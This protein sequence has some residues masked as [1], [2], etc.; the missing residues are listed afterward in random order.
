MRI[1]NLILL[2]LVVFFVSITTL[3]IA[4]DRSSGKTFTTRSEVLARN[5][6]VATNHPL[7]TQ[8]GIEILK[9][10]GSAI[11]AAIAANAFLGFAD[12]GMNGIGGDLFA[13]VW[14][15]KT[16]KLYGLNASGRSPQSLTLA[17]LKEQEQ[18]K[19]FHY[20]GPLSVTTPGCIDGWFELN[21]RFGK[22]T[23][24]E[25]LQPV[26]RYAREGVPITQE[27]A[28]NFLEMEESVQQSDNKNF[29]TLYFTNGQFPRK[30]EIFTN[31]DLATTLEI[32]SKKG[33]DGFYKGEVAQKIEAHMKSAGGFLTADDLAK[34][35]SEWV[36]PVSV[37]YRGY[38]VWELP[39]NGQGM[40]ALQMLTILEGFDLS[41]M[42]YGSAD[43]LHHFLEAKKMAY[44]D[45]VA[46]Y[47][48][49]AFGKIPIEELISKDYGAKR[50]AL[51][52]PN[53]AG[54][55]H[56]GLNSG[57][58]TIYL[59]AADKE[60]NMVSFIQS[61]SALFGS[62]EVPSG[63]GF[64]LHNRGGGFILKEGHINTYAPG[65]RPFHT[66]IPAFVTKDGKPFMS[67]GVMG[68][69]MQTQGHVQI[70]MNIIDFGMN[71]QE[72]GDAPRVYHRGTI[73]SSGHIDNVGDTY[74]E[75][76]F[77]Y[78]VLRDL[79]NKG[80]SI[81]MSTGIFGGYQAIM[82]KGGVYYGASE[83]RK[84][85]QAAGY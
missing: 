67:F 12:P 11:D 4:Q 75:S 17:Y 68:G 49:P 15:A 52:N 72:A 39:P 5:G 79:M 45:M 33:R 29:K 57:D 83:S 28:D 55:Y 63:L 77:S 27:T 3:V 53:K 32:I 40:A 35:H 43:H 82:L 66:I 70:I 84:D 41:K 8:I 26:I 34:H 42:G 9:K 44:E 37:N 80:H 46:F 62:R 74:V 38:D 21:K 81:R 23:M 76:G 24:S 85:G 60:G 36:D 69:D 10:G 2:I 78:D 56:S 31:T 1:F 65:K 61:N 51:I 16:K 20:R 18:R 6:M 13:I 14:D 64:V 47:G 71:L 19:N 30:G 50:R 54:I 48:D 25:L 58:H 7:A 59:T 22:L 73:S